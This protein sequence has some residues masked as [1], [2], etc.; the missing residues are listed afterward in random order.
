MIRETY[1][2][3]DYL[4]KHP[5]WHA[6]D[7]PWKAT[8]I[9]RMLARN[10]L[11]PMTVCEVGCGAGEILRQLQLKMD[12]RC[13]FWG[14]EVS[15]QAFE[16]C[17]SRAN[18]RLHFEPGDLV[19]D[20]RGKWDLL[21]VMDVIEHL[22]NYFEF[23]RAIRCQGRYKI[24]HVPLEMTVWTMLW[25]SIFAINRVSMGHIHVFNKHF[26]LDALQDTGYEVVDWFYTTPAID[27]RPTT[28]KA[29]MARAVKNLAF[30]LHQDLAARSFLGFSLMVLAK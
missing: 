6:Q 4:Q 8:Q 12:S 22:E 16:K 23:L 13:E 24:F 7:S 11:A 10:S 5:D 17:L 3:G 28:F 26:L 27:Q 21:L 2:Q 29:R 25:P 15:P 9:L 20:S 14:Y 30:G 18:A 19:A 1:S